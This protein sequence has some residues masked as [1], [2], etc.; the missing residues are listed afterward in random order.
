MRADVRANLAATLDETIA[1][2]EVRRE[3]RW[4]EGLIIA[5]PAFALA[6]LF[7][8]GR[9]VE[10]ANVERPLFST[11]ARKTAPGGGRAPHSTLVFRL[12]GRGCIATVRIHSHDGKDVIARGK[13]TRSV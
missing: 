10:R 2:D 8:F 3:A 13:I 7:G 9:H 6:A 1:Q 5:L 11:R 12:S 4:T